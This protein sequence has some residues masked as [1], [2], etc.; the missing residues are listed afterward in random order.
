[1][2]IKTTDHLLSL[3][4]LA[5]SQRD[6]QEAINIF[7][8]ILSRERDNHQAWIGLAEVLYL[9][10]DSYGS[11]WAYNR[12][13]AISKKESLREKVQKIEEEVSNLMRTTLSY[14]TNFVT[15]GPFIFKI[16]GKKKEKFTVRGINVGLGLPGYFP[17]EYPIKKSTYLEWFHLIAELGLN[18]IRI[19]TL[20]PPAF[21]EALYEFN[22][23]RPRLFLL[24]GI[25]YEP[26]PNHNLDEPKFIEGLKRHIM[27]VVDAIHGNAVLPERPGLPGGRYIF[28]ISSCLLGYLF[29][30]EPEVCLVKD[31]NKIRDNRIAD[32]EGKYIRITEGTPFEIWNAQILDEILKYSSERYGKLPL[33]SVVNWPTLD[34]LSHPSES[35][36]EEEAQFFWGQ[37]IGE[38]QCVENE[39]EERFDTARIHCVPKK[40]FSS[41]HIYPNYPDFMNYSFLNEENPY[42]SYLK[43]LKSHYKDQ[44]LLIAEFGVP[45]SRVS[46]HWHVKGWSHGAIDEDSQGKILIEMIKSIEKA[47]CAGYII[48]SLFDEWFKSTWLFNRFYIPRD[49][50]PKWFNFQDPEENYGLLEVY[51]GY[52][53]KAITLSGNRKE[54]EKAQI[55]YKRDDIKEEK[56]FKNLKIYH[57]EGFLYIGVEAKQTFDFRTTE[58]IIGLDTGYASEGE[59][60]FPF[61]HKIT[62]PIGLKFLIYISGEGSSRILV[63]SSYNKFLKSLFISMDEIIY[64][65]KSDDGSWNLMTILTNRRRVS[66]DKKR[67]YGPKTFIISNLKFGSLD[68]GNSNFN[69]LADFYYK[70][71]FLEIRLPWELLNFTDPSSGKILWQKE[72][73]TTKVSDG[74]RV[75]ALCYEKDSRNPLGTRRLVDTLP[76]PF[77]YKEVKTYCTEPWEYPTFHIRPKR[78][79]QVLRQFLRGQK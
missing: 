56:F 18:C 9:S 61:D 7:K 26:P 48:F 50:K 10:G 6:Y 14:Q 37:K 65:E 68:E 21:Y 11:L 78:I 46:A 2:S 43:K 24:Q 32:F 36:I 63:Q 27:E 76:D 73:L 39:D 28:D 75:V 13:Y 60:R 69:S 34:P 47:E 16:S 22:Q 35:K 62:S 67:I 79:Y 59:I 52:P 5:I 3:A 44:A 33:V 54:W 41:Y 40:Y 12:A 25:W 17:G 70:D 1:M 23:D 72:G 66:K 53:G 31:Y 20:H 64:P 42:F 38:G 71:N 74:I 51:P 57:D 30:R 8:E 15:E 77:E 58:V 19:Y 29:G 55:I 4:K 49:R 45:T